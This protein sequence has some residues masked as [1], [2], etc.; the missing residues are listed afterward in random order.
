MTDFSA[1]LHQAA[2]IAETRWDP[3]GFGIVHILEAAAPPGSSPDHVD[4][5]DTVVTH[6]REELTVPWE[7]RPGRTRADVAAMLR[8][9]ARP[10]SA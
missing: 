5:W 9:A 6:L 1:A 3:D 2:D 7:Q 4:L 10:A 8:A